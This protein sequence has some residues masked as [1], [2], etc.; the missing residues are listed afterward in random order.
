MLL[1]GWIWFH[2]NN[3]TFFKYNT[4]SENAPYFL[5]KKK[6]VLFCTCDPPLSRES[7]QWKSTF[8]HE[9]THKAHID[10]RKFQHTRMPGPY[11]LKQHKWTQ[12]QASSWNFR[13]VCWP[14]TNRLPSARL[15]AFLSVFYRPNVSA[16]EGESAA[17]ATSTDTITSCSTLSPLNTRFPAGKCAGQGKCAHAYTLMHYDHWRTQRPVKNSKNNKIIKSCIGKCICMSCYGN[18]PTIHLGP[19]A[20]VIYGINFLPT[21]FYC[22]D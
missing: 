7:E 18:W 11:K 21:V 1:S 4:I 22:Y 13:C 8:P 19:Y 5:G 17:S 10:G 12:S 14:K 2:R 6:T 20:K 3:E 16:R 9:N 15:S